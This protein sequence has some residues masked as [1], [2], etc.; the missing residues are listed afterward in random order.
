MIILNKRWQSY[1][2]ADRQ[3]S[4]TDFLKQFFENWKKIYF[5]NYFHTHSTIEIHS[6]P[7][8]S[9]GIWNCCSKTSHHFSNFLGPRNFCSLFCFCWNLCC[10]ECVRSCCCYWSCALCA[11]STS[12]SSS[13]R[14]FYLNFL[15]V[16]FLYVFDRAVPSSAFSAF[17][18]TNRPQFSVF[19]RFLSPPLSFS[20]YSFF[21][22]NSVGFE[23]PRD[24]DFWVFPLKKVAFCC[25]VPTTST[26][27]SV[28]SVAAA[29]ATI[30]TT[31]PTVLTKSELQ[32][33]LQKTSSSFSS[34]LAT[35][36]TTSSHVSFL[37]LFF[38]K[39]FCI[40]EVFCQNWKKNRDK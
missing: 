22:Q 35:T 27:C 7:R 37:K 9:N 19:L 33:T 26:S 8:F 21:Q 40:A 30:N 3:N 12:S 11:S 18:L 10:S 32:K 17:F 20:F 4:A 31:A 25:R 13:L 24:A 2:A 23:I 5:Q 16:F 6:F 29:T 1:V 34:S 36:T 39:F 38:L 28:A 14:L 15:R